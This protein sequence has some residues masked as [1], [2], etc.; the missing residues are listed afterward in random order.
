MWL[1][2]IQNVQFVIKK[3]FEEVLVIQ[4]DVLVSFSPPVLNY[5]S[6]VLLY[7]ESQEV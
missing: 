4:F 2:I 5:S 7:L 6:T 1:G 3:P